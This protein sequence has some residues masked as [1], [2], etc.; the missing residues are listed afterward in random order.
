MQLTRIFA[1]YLNKRNQK[2]IKL[3]R[4]GKTIKEIAFK[5]RL[6]ERHIRRILKKADI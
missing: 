2:I 4:K 5:F 3:R 6:S 1:N